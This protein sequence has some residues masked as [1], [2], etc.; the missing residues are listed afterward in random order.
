MF[1][2]FLSFLKT[3][4]KQNSNTALKADLKKKLTWNC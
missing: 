4:A 2:L 3:G 1:S